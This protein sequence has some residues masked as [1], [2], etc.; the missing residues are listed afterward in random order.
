MKDEY[1]RYATIAKIEDGDT[2][3]AEINL[4]FDVKYMIPLRLVDVFAFETSG[5]EKILGVK[6]KE[7]LENIIPLNSKVLI[8]TLKTKS[9]KNKKS[10]DRFIA[11]IWLEDG[12]CVNDILKEKTRGGIGTT[13][14][15]KQG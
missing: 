8:Q 11:K 3:L 9:G 10:F 14:L 6:D 12:T 7:S 4:G 1:I 13:K 2:V 5:S 15:K